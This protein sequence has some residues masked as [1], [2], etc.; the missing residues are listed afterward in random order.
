MKK[1]VI[2]I[3]ADVHVDPNSRERQRAFGYLTYVSA[4][5]QA[6][7]VPMIIPPQ[8]ENAGDVIALIDGL[9]L[10]GGYDCDPQIY[11]EEPHHTVEAMDN[12]RQA[13]D[14]ALARIARTENVP[15]L[16]ICLGAQ[17]MSVAAG[18]SLVQDIASHFES[19]IE[20][21]SDPSDR[22][23]H[24]VTIEKGSRLEK[25]LKQNHLEVNSSHHQAVKNPGAGLRI[26]AYAPDGVVEGVEDPAHPFY[27][28]VQWH[29][30]DMMSRP[31][32]VELFAAFI[33]SARQHAAQKN[34]SK[35]A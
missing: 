35:Q 28:G 11:G 7:A 25:I 14:I 19:T 6:G 12:R 26:C 27:L 21:S 22:V 4:V 1:P 17:V 23:W 9:L 10:A 32:A 31:L 13:N 8:P 33:E 20:H 15:T 18:G 3:G 5:L 16:G 29:P 2:G 24:D 30:E 34:G